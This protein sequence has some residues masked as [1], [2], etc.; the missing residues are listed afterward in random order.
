[1]AKEGESVRGLI[2]TDTVSDELLYALCSIV[3]AN[4]LDIDLKRYHL[5][6]GRLALERA[7]PTVRIVDK[8]LE[9]MSPN[10]QKQLLERSCTRTPST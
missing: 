10:E 9:D 7:S 2:V 6:E 4:G 8:L 1:M 3:I 5:K